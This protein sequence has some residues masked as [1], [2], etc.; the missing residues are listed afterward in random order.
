[1]EILTSMSALYNP[2]LEK[3]LVKTRCNSLSKT[4][5]ISIRVEKPI[6]PLL[7]DFQ[8]FQ[9][10]NCLETISTCSTSAELSSYSHMTWLDIDTI[11][12]T[13][14]MLQN[15]KRD[16]SCMRRILIIISIK[17]FWQSRSH[18]QLGVDFDSINVNCWRWNIFISYEV[19]ALI[20]SMSLRALLTVSRTSY[21]DETKAI[22]ELKLWWTSSDHGIMENGIRL[23]NLNATISQHID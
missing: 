12:Q 10:E 22:S 20:I 8:S 14:Q 5:P 23:E 2:Q 6:L 15:L 1:M 21:G 9:L 19:V 4:F 3:S 11:H 7:N 16:C 13:T 18:T 17:Y